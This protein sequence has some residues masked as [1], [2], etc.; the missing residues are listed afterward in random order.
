METKEREVTKVG[1]ARWK[2]L[3]SHVN[4]RQ[5]AVAL[6]RALLAFAS[7]ALRAGSQVRDTSG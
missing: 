4:M 2:R 1:D 7:A 3:S 6:Q 5:S